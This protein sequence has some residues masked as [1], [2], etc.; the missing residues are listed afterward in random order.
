MRGTGIGSYR[1]VRDRICELVEPVVESEG[2][3][4]VDCEWI[5]GR[6]RGIVRLFIDKDGG[7]T[8]DDCALISNQV[9]DIL[10]VYNVPSG[11]YNLE[12]SSPG[13]DR[14]LTRE[15]DFIRFQGETVMICLTEKVNGRKNYTGRLEDCRFDEHEKTIILDVDGEK[16]HIP[17]D[18]VAKA[19]LHY[20]F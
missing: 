6:S 8:V 1:D 12:V 17:Y 18:R 16:H 14:P 4:L 10:D 3:D 19:H 13:L 20:E 7:I 11:P 5:P 9:G 2:M 15:K